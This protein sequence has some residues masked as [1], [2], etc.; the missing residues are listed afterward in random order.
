MTQASGEELRYIATVA[1]QST[2]LN[3]RIGGIGVPYGKMSLLLPGGFYEVVEPGALAKSLAAK[4][5]I[6]S[7]L[8]HHPEWLLAS[9]AG[10]TMRVDDTEQGL[11]YDLDLPS[12]SAGRDTYALVK[13]GDLRGASMS[14]TAIEQEFRHEG[15]ALVRHLLEIRCTEI[16]PVAQPAYGDETST[17]LRSLAAQV[18]ADPDDVFALAQRS[19]LRSLFTV[20]HQFVSATPTV[21]PGHMAET[22]QARTMDPIECLKVLDSR[23]TMDPDVALRLL[24]SRKKAEDSGFREPPRAPQL[25]RHGHSTD[26]HPGQR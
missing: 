6:V 19:E 23:R 8:E 17:A 22:R 13:R 14:F 15:A 2:E 16:S 7:R 20:T 24:D 4:T 11:L 1:D 10:K 25:D 9:T 26:W 3:R 5:N 21:E 18:N 12:T